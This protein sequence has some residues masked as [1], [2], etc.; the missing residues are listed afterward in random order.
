MH[1]DGESNDEDICDDDIFEAYKLLYLKSKEECISS[2]KQKEKISVVL[3]DKKNPTTTISE[4]KEEVYHLNSKLVGM[5]KFVCMLNFGYET[6][7][8]IL[9]IGK[10]TKYM[11]GIEFDYSSLN[12]KYKFV[13]PVKRTELIMSNYMS[14]HPV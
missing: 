12:T 8:A 9:G 6:L 7:D 11:K 13:P 10:T 5:K 1:D 3:R 2:E 4:L 14:Q